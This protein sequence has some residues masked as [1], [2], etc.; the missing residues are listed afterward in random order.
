MSELA[1]HLTPQDE[2]EGRIP[3]HNRLFICPGQG[4]FFK[5]AMENKM[6]NLVLLKQKSENFYFPSHIGNQ[7][8]QEI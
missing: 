3:T 7:W 1:G 4:I 2:V 5:E 6:L 8:A